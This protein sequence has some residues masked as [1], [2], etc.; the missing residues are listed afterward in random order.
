M[1]S[2]ARL[3][4]T[5]PKD[6]LKQ[7]DRQIDGHS[8]RNRSH[9]IETLIRRSLTPVVTTAVILAGGKDV[10][11]EIPALRSIHDRKLIHI[12]INHLV[13]YGI[14]NLVILAGNQE[15]QVRRA[16]GDGAGTGITI[17]YANEGSPMGTA[18]ALKAAE[19]HLTHGPFLVMHGDVLTDINLPDFV[20]FHNNEKRMAT[21]AVKPRN[22]EPKYGK[23]MLQGNRITDFFDEDRSE[24]I[25]IVN[26]GV[27]LFEP[28][29]LSLLVEGQA[30]KLEK[31]VFPRLAEMG[32]LSAFLFQGIWF[33]ISEPENYS[34]AQERW[35]RDGRF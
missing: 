35:Q 3:T 25:S 10:G 32:E 34:R 22:A 33:D 19:E 24:G 9:A 6:L 2:K 26:T 21:I 28:E 20:N 31:D 13:D 8:I 16:V 4:I 27:Y 14:R 12:A 18:G 1:R 7:V 17:Q 30:A 23:V 29:L 15:K 5:L 11:G